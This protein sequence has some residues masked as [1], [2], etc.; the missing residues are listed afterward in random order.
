MYAGNRWSI[1]FAL[2]G[3][4]LLLLA[5]NSLLMAVGAYNVHARALA[6]CCMGCLG[7][8][9]IAAIITAAVFRWNT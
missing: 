7:C 5:A 3:I 2:C 6:S 4:T 9:N 1:V 8:V